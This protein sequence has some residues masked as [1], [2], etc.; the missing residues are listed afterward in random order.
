MKTKSCTHTRQNGSPTGHG[1]PAPVGPDDVRVKDNIDSICM[2]TYKAAVEGGSHNAYRTTSQSKKNPTIVGHEFCGDRRGGRKTGKHKYRPGGASP[3]SP[4]ITTRAPRW[5]RLL[6][7]LLRRRCPI[8][9]HTHRIAAY[10]PPTALRFRR[11]LYGSSQS[12]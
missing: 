1:R 6:L 11:M 9:Q 7:S 10:G 2:S 4:R 8:R 12:P 5:P 3:Y